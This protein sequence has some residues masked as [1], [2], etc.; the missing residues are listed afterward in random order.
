MTRPG[1]TGR[2]GR[3]RL[4]WPRPCPFELIKF[5]VRELSRLLSG[6][7]NRPGRLHSLLTNLTNLTNHRDGD[8]G[9]FQKVGIALCL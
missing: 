7:M 5:E 3:V 6:K 2:T 1:R 8:L 4:K 9:N